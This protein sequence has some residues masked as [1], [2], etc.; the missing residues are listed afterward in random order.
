[1]KAFFSRRL[2]F[3]NHHE[4]IFLLTRV[5][6]PLL[7]NIQVVTTW[8]PCRYDAFYSRQIKVTDTGRGI[9][10]MDIPQI[11]NRFYQVDDSLSRQGE[12]TGIGLALTK[13]LINLLG[14]RI[15]VISELGK[16]STFRVEL[17]ISNQAASE[18]QHAGI[19]LEEKTVFQHLAVSQTAEE[20]VNIWTTVLVL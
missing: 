20:K 1:M 14:G 12:G 8:S 3:F 10:A 5:K 2:T 19:E 6:V 9:P 7:H 15:N 4:F 16:G 11:F 18:E 13:E 17:P